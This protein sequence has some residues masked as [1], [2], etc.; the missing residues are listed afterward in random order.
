L[1]SAVDIDDCA[2]EVT[3]LDLL[4]HDIAY[5]KNALEGI[6]DFHVHSQF[7]E[8]V[9]NMHILPPRCKH[10]QLKHA[11]LSNPIEAIGLQRLRG[12]LDELALALPDSK[13]ADVLVRL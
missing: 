12:L 6:I 9:L 4:V 11:Q 8:G 5:K 3:Y 1:Q 13:R 2:V 10:C 7:F